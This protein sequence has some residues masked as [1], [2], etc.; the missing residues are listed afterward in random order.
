M[1]SRYDLMKESETLTSNNDYYPDICSLPTHKFVF[2][3]PPL[4][5]EITEGDKERPDIMMDRIFGYPELDDIIFFIN[6]KDYLED[7]EVGDKILLPSQGN[8]ERFYNKF[9]R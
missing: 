3:E 4:E 1:R 8:L 6:G 7:L 2:E 9:F 5:Y